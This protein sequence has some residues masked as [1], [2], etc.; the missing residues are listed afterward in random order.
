MQQCALRCSCWTMNLATSVTQIFEVATYWCFS[1]LSKNPLTLCII[2]AIKLS[3]RQCWI[4]DFFYLALQTDIDE[5]CAI[6]N[7]SWKDQYSQIRTSASLKSKVYSDL[8]NPTTVQCT[9]REP[10]CS[11]D[12]SISSIG[13]PR[14]SLQEYQWSFIVKDFMQSISI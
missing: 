8:L 5:D 1:F 10:C 11:C 3:A 14:S 13:A 6:M 2:Q 7:R 9:N 4:L 12:S